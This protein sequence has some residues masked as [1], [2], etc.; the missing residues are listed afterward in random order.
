MDKSSVNYRLIPIPTQ[1]SVLFLLSESLTFC[2]FKNV[3]IINI[4][5]LFT[6]SENFSPF[7]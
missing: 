1:L 5:Q 2:F 4:A 6:L 3:F 7:S